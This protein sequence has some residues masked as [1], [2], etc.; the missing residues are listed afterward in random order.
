MRGV[1]FQRLQEGLAASE[2][3][4]LATVVEGPGLGGQMLIWPGGQSLGEVGTPDLN[5]RAMELA[6]QALVEMASRRHSLDQDGDS[7][8]IFFEVFPPPPKLILVG[9][10]HVAISLITYAK[11][12]GFRC[13]V[14]D[15]RTAF[16]TPERFA[17]ADRLIQDWPTKALEEEGIS[18][19]TYLAVLS[20]DLKIDLPALEAGL[21]SP[22]RYIGAL[23]SKKTHAKRVAALQESGFSD[24]DIGRIQAPIGLDLGGRR[25]EEIALSIIAQVVAAR[26]GRTS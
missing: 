25:A 3:F 9:A 16:A 7:V 14:I 10:V 24:Q 11:Q 12:L 26:Y 1:I 5:R 15:P 20:H 22:A 6:D 21:R 23:G 18:G 4:A 2:L 17:A 8:D 19:N 13:I